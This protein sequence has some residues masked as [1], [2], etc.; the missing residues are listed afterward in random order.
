MFVVFCFVKGCLFCQRISVL[1]KDVTI[2]RRLGPSAPD[3]F[4]TS[5]RILVLLSQAKVS[6]YFSNNPFIREIG[7]P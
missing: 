3:F 5:H 1:S 4:D 7:A 6:D 2:T